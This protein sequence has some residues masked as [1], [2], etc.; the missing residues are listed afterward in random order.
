MNNQKKKTTAYSK[1]NSKQIKDLNLKAKITKFFEENRGGNLHGIGFGNDFFL[2]MIRKAQ[3]MREKIDQ[4]NFIKIKTFCTSKD[5][6]TECKGNLWHWKKYLQII[7]DKRII[8]R[9]YRT[10]LQHNHNNK[11]PNF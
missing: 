3:S 6:I 7:S 9:I 2:D 10:L 8:S 4:L 11:K 1:T 5:T